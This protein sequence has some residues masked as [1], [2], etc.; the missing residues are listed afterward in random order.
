MFFILHFTSNY[1]SIHKILV[2]T[3]ININIYSLLNSKY[4]YLNCYIYIIIINSFK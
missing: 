3:R 1:L 4:R 2:Y